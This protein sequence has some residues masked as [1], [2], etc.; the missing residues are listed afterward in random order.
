MKLGI[1]V[2]L[3]GFYLFSYFAFLY[4]PASTEFPYLRERLGTILSQS[5]TPLHQ[6]FDHIP[7]SFYDSTQAFH[8]YC[9]YP[10]AEITFPNKSGEYIIRR[11]DDISDCQG[12]YGA[13]IFREG[14]WVSEIEKLWW[15]K[16]QY[17][18]EQQKKPDQQT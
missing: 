4:K 9:Y 5:S 11:V 10:S 12:W 1:L 7:H 14:N 17:L 2:F 8:V 6:K 13:A 3:T 16:D 15:N 18:V